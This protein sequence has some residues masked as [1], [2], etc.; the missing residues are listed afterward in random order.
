MIAETIS[1]GILTLAQAF[2][3]LGII[4][5][6]TLIVA[7]GI[8]TALTAHIL[9]L[10]IQQEGVDSL[11]KAAEVRWKRWHLRETFLHI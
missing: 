3:F 10:F 8:I 2:A 9:Y 1:L 7:A 6:C 5:G 4:P 11:P